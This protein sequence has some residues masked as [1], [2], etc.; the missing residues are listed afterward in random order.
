[1]PKLIDYPRASFFRVVE[2]AEAID[3]LGG[4]CTIQ[5]CAEKMGVKVTGAFTALV[6]AAKKHGLVASEKNSLKTT[7]LYKN[8]RLAYDDHEKQQNFRIAFLTPPL[9]RKIYE[10]FLGKELPINMLDKLMIREFGVDEDTAQRVMNYFL[11]GAKTYKILVENKIVDIEIKKEA[12]I[13]N[14]QNDQEDEEVI[15]LANDNGTEVKVKDN[16]G[17]DIYSAPNQ[18]SL[19]TDSSESYTIHIYGPGINSKLSLSEE[20]DFLILDAT[21]TKLRKKFKKIN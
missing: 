17:L 2:M 6:G 15:E 3:Y 5:T 18:V 7:Q 8:I 10:R 11:E 19:N 13:S 9:Y 16:Y 4:T 21:V 20:D 1:M 12:L 14:E